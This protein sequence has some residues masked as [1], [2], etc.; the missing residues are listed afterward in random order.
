MSL[1]ESYRGFAI[2]LERAGSWQAKI[3]ETSTGALLPTMAT[4][5]V[6]E[7]QAAAL[8]R[9]RKLVDIYA[10]ALDCERAA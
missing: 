4:A 8:L 7:G 1:T 5:L 6:H 10:D 3:V 2:R 9:A